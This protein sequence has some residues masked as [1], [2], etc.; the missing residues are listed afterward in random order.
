LLGGE[1]GRGQAGPMDRR[2]EAVARPGEVV[3]GRARPQA[4]VDAHEEHVEIG[5]DDILDL[6]VDGCAQVIGRWSVAG[7]MSR[8]VRRRIYFPPT[9]LPPPLGFLPPPLLPG[10][11]S[12]TDLLPSD[13]GSEM[14]ECW[15]SR[16]SLSNGLGLTMAE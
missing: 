8:G 3:T 10:P 5:S 11:L 9:F 2:P 7:A 1:E 14:A 13:L 15:P 4:R 16:S 6:F 12:P